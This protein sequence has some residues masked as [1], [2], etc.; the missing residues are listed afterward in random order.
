MP[1]SKALGP[2]RR[3]NVYPAK[4]VEAVLRL[5]EHKDTSALRSLLP[6]F[7]ISVNVLIDVISQ[8]ALIW[9]LPVV[10]VL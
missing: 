9:Y 7:W 5:P 6:L 3:S 2:T 8:S 10:S 1:G 4:L